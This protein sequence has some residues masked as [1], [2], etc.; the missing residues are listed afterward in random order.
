MNM[1]QPQKNMLQPHQQ[2]PQSS[3][4]PNRLL[5]TLIE[6]LRIK[7]DSALSNKLRVAKSIIR[8]IRQRRLP[9]GASMLMWMSE[10]TGM[11]IGELRALLGDRRAKNRLRFA[12]V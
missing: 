4:N 7:D 9:V 8:D 11:S 5:D 10:A 3:Y 6:R 2:K 12:L 1:L